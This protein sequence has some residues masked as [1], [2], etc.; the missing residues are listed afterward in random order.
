MPPAQSSTA[1][2]WAVLPSLLWFVLVVVLLVVMNPA[3][4][5]LLRLPTNHLEDLFRSVRAFALSSK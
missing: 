4:A 1:P 2:G 3:M 5:F